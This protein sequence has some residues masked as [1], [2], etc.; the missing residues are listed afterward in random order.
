MRIL[1]MTFVGMGMSYSR[2][3]AESVPPLASSVGSYKCS[4]SSDS[5]ALGDD[6]VLPSELVSSLLR[7][8]SPADLHSLVI[9]DTGATDH[10]LPDRLAFISYKSVCSLRVWMGNN[11]HAPVLGWGTAIVSLNGQRL[12]IRNVL[13]VPALWVPLYSLCAHLRQCGCG[14]VRSFDM[15][16]H[17]YF[18]GVV[19]SVDMS[20]D[21]HLSYEP[22]GKSAPLSS[23]H[24]V[25]PRCAPVHYPAKGSAFWAGAAPASPPLLRPSDA[26]VLIE[27]DGSSEDNDDATPP[28]D[29][30]ESG[31]PTFPS[32]VPKQVLRVSSKSFSPNNL[33][34]ISKQLQ[35]LSDHLSGI[36]VPPLPS[37][38][39][40][41]DSG[42]PV[43]DLDRHGFYRLSRRR[44]S[45][46]LFIVPVL[47]LHR[48]VRVIVLMAPTLKLTGLQK[49]FI[50][51]SAVVVSAITSISFRPASMVSGWLAASSRSLLVPLRRFRKLLG[52]RPSIMHSLSTLMLFMLTL[53]LGIVSPQ[54]V[55]DTLSS[56]LIVPLVTTGFLVSRICQVCQFSVLF[57]SFGLTRDLMLGVFGAIATLNFLGRRFGSTLL[58]ML[59]T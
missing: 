50:V 4:I 57:I 26:P 8:V 14:F 12:L 22:L 41:S 56:S 35:V 9:A 1:Q 54:V 19:L 42:A 46:G 25:Q 59:P 47:L 23:L 21:C 3:S 5:A 58:T 31:L 10:M 53:P 48:F 45:F 24:Y 7:A 2:V 18:P 55:S 33:A 44:M 20:T 37:P 30:V 34:L 11:S 27:D 15:G 36:T 52:E 32:L 6:I 28:A 39:A 17:V 13:H 43:S 29:D 51:P 38:P 40:V 16:M 49:S